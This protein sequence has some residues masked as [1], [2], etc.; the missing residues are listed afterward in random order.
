MWQRVVRIFVSAVN[1]WVQ[2]R[3]SPIFRP[4][5]FHDLGTIEKTRFTVSQRYQNHQNPHMGYRFTGA[6]MF[7][8]SWQARCVS[9]NKLMD[10]TYIDF[11][12][13][14]EPESSKNQK[15]PECQDW[16]TL[17]RRST[18]TKKTQYFVE[19]SLWR[20]TRISRDALGTLNICVHVPPDIYSLAPF[21]NIVP[22]TFFF[23]LWFVF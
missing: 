9:K 14:F 2:S 4:P 5:E 10:S 11:S 6:L 8:R 1:S 15:D 22:P 13:D 18:N 19:R 3:T 7:S 16:C 21:I 17:E 23:R 20:Y 12:N